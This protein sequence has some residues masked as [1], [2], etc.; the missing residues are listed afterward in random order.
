VTL[1]RAMQEGLANVHKHAEA[2]EVNITLSYMVDQVA[3]DIQDDGSGFELKTLTGSTGQENGGYGLQ[4]MR[5]RVEQIGGTIILESTPGNGTTL[6]IQIPIIDGGAE[7][8][9]TSG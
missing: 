7:S 5:Q 6:A 8:D 1:L 9:Q 2:E 3:L 4:A